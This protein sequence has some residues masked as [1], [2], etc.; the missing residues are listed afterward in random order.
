MPKLLEMDRR[1]KNHIA[2]KLERAQT[3][4]GLSNNGVVETILVSANDSIK[5]ALEDYSK[6]KLASNLVEKINQL[7]NI[8]RTSNDKSSTD[9]IINP[10][11]L[12]LN[13]GSIHDTDEVPPV[14]NRPSYL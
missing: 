2:R 14:N 1:L 6:D 7:L 5:E 4:I 8:V 13:A 10:L 3:N 12:T 9:L 11:L